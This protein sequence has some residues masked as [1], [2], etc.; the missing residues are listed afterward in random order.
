MG[1]RAHLLTRIRYCYW[2]W[3]CHVWDLVAGPL[4]PAP[5]ILQQQQKESDGALKKPMAAMMAMTMMLLP[6]CGGYCCRMP[7]PLPPPGTDPIPSI[8]AAG[9][10]RRR[11]PGMDQRGM[12]MLAAATSL[13]I[14]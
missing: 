7:P 6:L 4:P 10:R 12:P 5:A 1:G 13:E 3:A 14:G 8:V 11:D 2:V 9:L